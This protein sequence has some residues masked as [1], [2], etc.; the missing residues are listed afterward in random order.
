MSSEKAK[1]GQYRLA[2]KWEKVPLVRNRF[3]KGKD[4]IRMS[5]SEDGDLVLCTKTIQQNHQILTLLLDEFG[6]QSQSIDSLKA[7]A[8][9]VYVSQ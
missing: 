9:V 3:R 7:Q 6:M 8:R 4:W 5:F 2:R 1:L